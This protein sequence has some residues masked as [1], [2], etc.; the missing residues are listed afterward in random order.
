M[1]VI[2]IIFISHFLLVNGADLK[3][4]ESSSSDV[5]KELNLTLSEIDNIFKIANTTVE[6]LLK[7]IA[8][9]GKSTKLN[10]LLYLTLCGLT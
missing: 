3:R 9:I 5:S 6:Y 7:E 8:K 4:E 10:R 1:S 2:G